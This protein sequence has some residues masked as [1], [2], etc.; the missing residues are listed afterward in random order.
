MFCIKWI[1][2]ITPT[3]FNERDVEVQHVCAS[4]KKFAKE[5]GLQ[6][7]GEGLLE[8]ARRWLQ[9]DRIELQ[10]EHELPV[11]QDDGSL[12]AL[13]PL[14]RDKHRKQHREVW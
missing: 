11:Q 1:S 2:D 5:H 14:Y 3:E 9:E 8:M 10:P 12:S 13:E 6:L 4:A 7:Q